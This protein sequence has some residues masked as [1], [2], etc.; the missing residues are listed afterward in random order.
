MPKE[1]LSERLELARRLHDG[2]AQKLI[3]LGYRLDSLIGDLELSLAHRKELRQIRLDLIG[4]IEDLRDELYLISQRDFSSLKRELPTILPNF[5]V[6]ISLPQTDELTPIENSLATLIL[7][8]ARNSSKH[9]IGKRFWVRVELTDESISLRVGDDGKSS[10][11]I[12]ERSLG[13]KLINAQVHSLGGVIELHSS[14][15]GNEYAIEIPRP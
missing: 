7:E 14:S 10:I 12:K 1:E 13:L 4:L 3:A 8:I 15:N 9:S 2:P 5:T 6:E 11:S